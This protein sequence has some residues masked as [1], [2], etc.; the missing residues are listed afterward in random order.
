MLQ[1]TYTLLGNL[2]NK[3]R[4]WAAVAVQFSYDQTDFN[5]SVRSCTPCTWKLPALETST[6]GVE[7][8]KN[9]VLTL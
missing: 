2:H 1:H 8:T 4:I 5:S 7:E 3:G 9:V 6:V